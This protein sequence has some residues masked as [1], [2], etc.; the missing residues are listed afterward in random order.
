MASTLDARNNFLDGISNIDDIV[1]RIALGPQEEVIG[2]INNLNQRWNTDFRCTPTFRW[3]PGFYKKLKEQSGRISNVNVQ[4]NKVSTYKNQIQNGRWNIDQFL[5][6]IEEIDTKLYFLRNSGIIF[7]D[8]TEDVN[9]CLNEYKVKI[10]ETMIT[11]LELY[12]NMNLSVYHGLHV[13]GYH[14]SR[15]YNGTN[16]AISFHIY[17]ESVIMNINI[18]GETVAV[19]MGD[20]DVIISVDLVK[21]VMN[22]IRQV[23]ITQGAMGSGHTNPWNGA[24][25]HPQER[26]I[27]FPYISE[28]RWNRDQLRVAFAEGQNT[29]SG[30]S[31][32]CFGSFDAEIKEAAWTGDM[33]ALFTYL[34]N[35]TKNFNVGSTGPLNGYDKMFHGI[36]PEMLTDVWRSTG[37]MDPAHRMDNCK[38]ADYQNVQFMSDLDLPS[39]EESYCDRYECVLRSGCQSYKSIYE[40]E[41]IEDGN[42]LADQDGETPFGPELNRLTEAE[43][44]EMYQGVNTVDIRR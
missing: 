17:I 22:R 32:V 44:L 13:N 35:W 36:W 16:H 37:N 42:E 27:L 43:I 26:D 6:K 30:F 39:K 20:L 7:Q 3:Q 34:D 31:N 25:F 41:T 8:N 29:R 9:R 28:E 2:L 24:I 4:K 14:N 38:Y 19:P 1:E 5:T 40:P 23:N 18:G 12:P 10:E 15:S 21:N 11:A 33:I